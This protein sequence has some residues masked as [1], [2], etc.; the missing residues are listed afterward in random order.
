MF[1]PLPTWFIYGP[2]YLASFTLSI[3]AM[4]QGRIASG[5]ILLLVNIICVPVLYMFAVAVGI[6]TWSG[7]VDNVVQQVKQ[8]PTTVLAAAQ[9]AEDTGSVPATTQFEKIEG[10]FGVRL[11]DVFDLSQ[12]LGNRELGEDSPMYGF[13]TEKGF[14]SFK[15][16]YVVV[17]PTTHRI[18]CIV[19]TGSLKDRSTAEKE[20]AVVL[21]LL[22]EKYGEPFSNRIFRSLGNIATITQGQRYIVTKITGLEHVSIEIRYCDKELMDLAEKERLAAEVEK[23][24]KTAL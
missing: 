1:I 10:A 16:Y 17:T 12:A 3:V 23:V 18:C 22:K 6:L 24:D 7:W 8:D 20:Q 5:A 9:V 19:G 11:G 14:R 4:A 21:E 13:A 15:L 2:L